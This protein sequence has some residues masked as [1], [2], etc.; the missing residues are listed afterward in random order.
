MGEE[1]QKNRMNMV[2][3]H[4]I[5]DSVVKEMAKHL[6]T[7]GDASWEALADLFRLSQVDIQAIRYR[8]GI[9]KHCSPALMFFRDYCMPADLSV[10]RL[11]DGLEEI[12]NI[13]CMRVLCAWFDS[14]KPQNMS[15]G[16][17]R[18]AQ[19]PASSNHK[20]DSGINS[21][22]SKDDELWRRVNDIGSR[23][24]CAA[25]MPLNIPV[26]NGD[27]MSNMPTEC[28]GE[29]V[30]T[31]VVDDYT[32]TNNGSQGLD[33]RITPCHE[34]KQPLRS[35]TRKPSSTAVKM[36]TDDSKDTK[37]PLL[38]LGCDARILPADK[39][40]DVAKW[41]EEQCEFTQSSSIVREDNCH[42]PKNDKPSARDKLI[43]RISHPFTQGDKKRLEGVEGQVT[44]GPTCATLTDVQHS[45]FVQDTR[46]VR[47]FL[48][49]TYDNKQHMKNV[50]HVCDWLK[51]NNF[52]VGLDARESSVLRKDAERARWH[53]MRYDKA[54][55]VLVL[56]SPLYSRV[57]SGQTR[58]EDGGESNVLHAQHIYERMHAEHRTNVSNGCK[59]TRRFVPVVMSG[60]TTSNVPE[61]LRKSSQL[62]SWPQQYQHLMYYLIQPAQVIANYVSK[63]NRALPYGRN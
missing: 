46:H 53:N 36:E 9:G 60:A 5:P 63:W 6:D 54:D 17:R 41:I 19:S 7:N 4:N 37:L 18:H 23:S 30:Y 42:K 48:T 2:T 34:E 62:F 1:R 50:L 27:L 31:E 32:T 38:G 45:D 51:K 28:N 52:S 11:I 59:T 20:I 35:C 40:E 16:N 29:Y 57:V 49:Y 10:D 3:F 12:G 44:N 47:V 33:L 25:D 15:I 13:A 43:R 24:Y 39:A 55:Y 56:V 22:A 21:P 61:W 14:Y 26:Q 58:P 8:A